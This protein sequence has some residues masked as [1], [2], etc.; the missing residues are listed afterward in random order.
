MP[1][2][3]VTQ[4]LTDPAV[5]DTFDVVRRSQTI[6]DAGRAQVTLV[7]FNGIYGVVFP[8]KPDDLNRLPEEELG[9]KA[10]TVITQFLLRP[11]SED[12]GKQD[13]Y[14]DIVVWNNDNFLVQIMDDY[15]RYAAGF[16]YAICTLLDLN[17]VPPEL[18][19]G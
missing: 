19:N 11:A 18:M 8:S 17:Q 2:I 13:Y 16:I 4:S 1:L 6:S 14:P 3:D 10:I 9:N 7:P 5:L 15:S 12:K